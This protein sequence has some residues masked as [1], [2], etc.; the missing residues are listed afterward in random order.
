[1]NSRNGIRLSLLLL[2]LCALGCGKSGPERAAIEGNVT[3]NGQAL[4]E[5][6]IT[7]FPTKGGVTAGGKIENGRYSLDADQGPTLGPNRIKVNAFGKSGRKEYVTY[8]DPTSG[9]KD[10]VIE[11]IPAKYNVKSTLEFDVQSGTNTYDLNL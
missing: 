11:I 8:G 10:E 9:L 7:F 5:G 1:M 2:A 4:K 6:T 3:F